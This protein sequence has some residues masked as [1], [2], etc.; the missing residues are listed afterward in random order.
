MKR[1]WVRPM[2]RVLAV[3]A[4]LFWCAAAPGGD[5][6]DTYQFDQLWPRLQQPWYFFRPGGVALD[7]ANNLFVADTSNNRI[8]KFTSDGQYITQFGQFGGAPGEFNFPRGLAIGPD[9]VGVPRLF[10]ADTNNLRVQV[11]DLQGRPLRQIETR[12]NGAGEPFPPTGVAVDHLG[13]LYITAGDTL[14]VQKISLLGIVTE[15]VGDGT[16]DPSIVSCDPD[17]IPCG[18]PPGIAVDND[19]HVFVADPVNFRVIR[20]S[21]ALEFQLAFGEAGQPDGNAGAPFYVPFGL[22]IARNGDVVVTDAFNG[23]IQRFDNDGNFLEL[24]G[25]S[26]VRPGE[27][28]HIEA[29]ALD[30][31]DNIYVAD[32]TNDRV[33]KF[34][35]DGRLIHQI[36][37]SGDREGA[38]TFP[39]DVAVDG[40]G[41]TFVADTDNHRIQRFDTDARFNLT[42]GEPGRGEPGLFARP[43][44]IAIDPQSGR[45]YVAD[46]DSSNSGTPPRFQIFEP[47]GEFVSER[48][49]P[50][51]MGEEGVRDETVF[52]TGIAVDKDGNVFVVQSSFVNFAIPEG[53]N[54]PVRHRV[55]RFD[56]EGGVITFGRYGAAEGQFDA[57]QDIAVNDDGNVYVADT[58][59]HRIQK[60]SNTGDFL[61]AWGEFGTQTGQFNEPGGVAIGPNKTVFVADTMNHRIQVFTEDGAFITSIGGPGDSPGQF[62]RPAGLDVGPDG[63]LYV[64]DSRHNRI[65][66][67]LPESG[68][69]RNRAVIIASG[70]DIPDN[71]L[72]P[73]TQ[74][75][76][77]LAYRTLEHQ[78]FTREDI[79]YLSA[80]VSLDLD[81]NGAA[82]NILPLTGAQMQSSLTE[83]AAEAENVLVY[84]TGLGR[85]DVF[86]LNQTEELRDTEL[87][88]YLN[89]LQSEIGG[90]LLVVYD[91]SQ[92][93][94]FIDAIGANDQGKRKIIASTAAN[95]PAFFLTGGTLSFSYIMLQNMFNGMSEGQAIL[96]SQSTLGTTFAYQTPQIETDGNGIPDE[97]GDEL[98]TEFVFLKGVDSY[99]APPAADEVSPDM[100]VE[101]DETTA[102]FFVRGAQDDTGNVVRAWCIVTWPTALKSA[103]NVVTTRASFELDDQ[104]GGEFTATYDNLQ[105]SG[106]YTI[107]VLAM[108]SNMNVTAV[109]QI[110]LV[111]AALC[112]PATSCAS[113]AMQ[114]HWSP[115]WTLPFSAS[116]AM[117]PSPSIST[118]ST[119]SPD[120]PM[121]NTRSPPARRPT[122][123]HHK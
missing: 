8:R 89:T 101:A 72:W 106:E 46:T 20:L 82:D 85:R 10:V 67:L 81:S 49:I 62:L 84:M 113:C 105:P 108:D 60:L 123:P 110:K 116:P 7:S 4:M 32:T 112:S 58:F 120:C 77:N 103:S 71:G 51:V 92:S 118:A 31:E 91:A 98:G 34:T 19:G 53:D 122:P 42:W 64:A 41:N 96:S 114:P 43:Q 22:D 88:E 35:P 37:S 76:A 104:G 80:D 61:L 44:G 25:E 50:N 78:G 3:P 107:D 111:K 39:T 24:F 16:A 79:R 117:W 28:G 47:T 18:W 121:A 38:F 13:N 29:L 36:G 99:D 73:A 27:L 63:T 21:D 69:P 65:Q 14:R 23:R 115:S 33:Q 5:D 100:T 119:P 94:S 93:G 15:Y 55:Q 97:S 30:T 109:D 83:W 90:E 12:V 57:P 102:P 59:N 54:E 87:N 11:L 6:G 45:I 52:P 75:L 70:G 95:E 17:L 66:R 86:T 56:P 74:M 68:A 2:L 26:D 40:N 9:V 1:K 48:E